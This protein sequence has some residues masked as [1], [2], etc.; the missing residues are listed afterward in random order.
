MTWKSLRNQMILTE[1][2]SVPN[3]PDDT[4]FAFH[5]GVYDLLTLC[6]KPTAEYFKLLLYAMVIPEYR[7]RHHEELKKSKKHDA[8]MW[9]R[10]VVS[11]ENFAVETHVV[12]LI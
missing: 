6:R 2:E 10:L 9:P 11:E 1:N 12:D 8:V 3:W 7:R 5:V 4:L